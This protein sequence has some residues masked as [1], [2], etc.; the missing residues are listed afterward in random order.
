MSFAQDLFVVAPVLALVVAAAAV[1]LLTVSAGYWR[2]LS[3]GGGH[4]VVLALVGVG[5]AVAFLAQQQG[6]RS[7]FSGAVLVDPVAV[8]FGLVTLLA[9]AIGVVL[10][11]SYLVEHEHSQGEFIALILSST[12]GMLLV[13]MAGDLIALFLGIEIMSLGVYVLAGFRRSSRRSQEAALKYFVYGAFASAFVLFGIALLYGEVGRRLGAPGIALPQLA[14]AF[15]EPDRVA[16]LGWVGVALVLV[17]LGFKVAAV[18]FHMWAPDVYEG[19]PTPATGFMAVGIKAAAFAGLLRFLGQVVL[20]PSAHQQVTV[21]LL[22]VLAILTMV[23]G[24]LV[25]VRQAHI[26]RMLAYS[27]IAHAGYVL[28]GVAAYVADPQGKALSGIAYYLLGYTVMTLGAFGVVSAFERREDSRLDVAMER[29]RGAALRYPGLGLAM[30]VFMFSLAGVPPTAGF[31][32]K[33]SV[34]SAA[35]AAERVGVVIIGVLASVVGAFYY[36]RVL[37]MMYMQSEDAAEQRVR[38]PWLAV[39]L[40]ACALVTVVAGLLPQT[41]WS[42]ATHLGMPR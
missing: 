39:G 20:Q 11:Q 25:A 18:P 37:V 40:W 21:H 12:A 41:F 3:Q 24:N 16:Y 42:L 38:S 4:L 34:F 29:F 26:K 7:A 33:L 8:M 13:V 17:G 32:G 27:S 1:L 19:A 23:V 36:L 31:F 2:S 15:A 35:I 6:A 10:A 22:E 5:F 14:K 28:V 9:C 30:A